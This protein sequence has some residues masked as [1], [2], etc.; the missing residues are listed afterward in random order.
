MFSKQSIVISIL[1]IVYFKLPY[2]I[3]GTQL[4]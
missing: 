1:V 2:L 3:E 4:M